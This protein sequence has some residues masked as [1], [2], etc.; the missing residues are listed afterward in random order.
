MPA[1][2][3]IEAT[4][5]LRQ[6]THSFERDSES[7]ELIRSGFDQVL[8]EVFAGQIVIVREQL[9]GYRRFHGVGIFLVEVQ[10]DPSVSHE[11][12]LFHSPAVYIVKTAVPERRY[13]LLDEIL[14]WDGAHPKHV[15]SDNIFMSLNPFPQRGSGD[16]VALVYGDAATAL[17][18]RNVMSLEEAMYRSCRFGQPKPRSIVV[19][20]RVLYDRLA[21]HYFSRSQLAAAPEYLSENAGPSLSA[22]LKRWRETVAPGVYDP[23]AGVRNATETSADA[24]RHRLRREVLAMSADQHE[25]YADPVDV[26]TGLWEQRNEPGM[27][28]PVLRGFAHGDL[29]ARNIEVAVD[30]D[31]VVSCAL[32]DY[33]AMKP[34]NFVA[35]DFV[36]LEVEFAVRLLAHDATQRRKPY[37]G[38][39]LTYW[40]Y[41]A[42][43]VDAFDR[44]AAVGD[45]Q[46]SK[47]RRKALLN[48]DSRLAEDVRRLPKSI[49]RLADTAVAIRRIAKEHLQ[50]GFDWQRQYDLLLAWYG[51]RAGLYPN[52]LSDTNWIVAALVG[53][54]VSARRL[55]ADPSAAAAD[56]RLKGETSHRSR[57]L[58][59]RKLARGGDAAQLDAGIAELRALRAE[60]PHVLEIDEES[61]L[62]LI[63]SARTAEAEEVLRSIAQRYRSTTEESPARVGSL[64]KRRAVAN[65]KPDVA[66][67]KMSLEY[68]R[69][70]EAI[71]QGYFPAINVAALL[72]LLGDR[73]GAREQSRRVLQMLDRVDPLKDPFWPHATRGEAMLLCGDDPEAALR[74][75]ERAVSER[76]CTPR[77]RNSMRRQLE[78]LRPHLDPTVRATLT[79]AA[80]NQLF[81]F[82]E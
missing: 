26:L 4:E 25:T 11:P 63:E 45:V 57:F 12:G 53:A 50:G 47:A 43:R 44:D 23:L 46:D 62:A 60:Y 3:L 71:H 20:L 19:Q 32:F 22:V 10:P 8:C 48:L 33:E 58:R 27:L 74:C 76:D 78:W 39:C 52:Y 40:R 21:T 37:V 15:P 29:H 36:K 66:A 9:A 35:W 61:A 38:Q 77:D 80:L 64:W 24:D 81:N 34:D 54:G 65:S 73:S 14:A 28:P 59:A 6:A 56:E 49:L 75:Y 79:D 16:P 55:I 7:F 2:W 18:A 68:Y 82:T 13:A 30:R 41:V 67:L 17:G 51:V 5:S 31:R 69:R 42:A 1:I 72:C 70:A